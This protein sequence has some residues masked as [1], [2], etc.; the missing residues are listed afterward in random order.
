MWLN[1]PTPQAWH[2]VF[3][4]HITIKNVGVETARLFWRH[5][6]I[7]DQMTGDHEVEGEGVVGKSP[8]LE[9]GETHRYQSFCVLRGPVG[10]MEGFYHFR[11]L[12]GSVF[13]VPIPRFHLHGLSDTLNGVVN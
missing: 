3:V 6:L 9:P 12:D 7:H 10:Y 1:T 13:R 11:R 4:Y 2:H 5:W 8:L